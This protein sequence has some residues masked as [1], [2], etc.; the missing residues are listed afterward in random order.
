MHAPC[1]GEEGQEAELG[2]EHGLGVQGLSQSEPVLGEL[3]RPDA[4]A[5][6]VQM[7]QVPVMAFLVELGVAIWV[8]KGEEVDGWFLRCQLMKFE[9]PFE[10][11]MED[12]NNANT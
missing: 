8:V 6:R 3:F 2:E 10:T 11:R 4:R 12:P 5:L 9:I 1:N 7:V